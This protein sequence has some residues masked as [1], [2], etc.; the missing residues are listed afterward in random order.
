MRRLCFRIFFR[1]KLLNHIKVKN[2]S[3]LHAFLLFG[4]AAILESCGGSGSSSGPQSDPVLTEASGNIDQ[5]KATSMFDG[6]TE[7]ST[8]IQ[9]FGLEKVF[10]VDG[11]DNKIVN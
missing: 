3:V 8:G 9:G 1:H 5:N 6:D 7:L 10:I 11:D 2:T 4:C